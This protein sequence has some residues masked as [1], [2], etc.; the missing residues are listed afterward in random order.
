MN[1]LAVAVLGLASVF[2]AQAALAD[3]LETYKF[4]SDVPYSI[5]GPNQNHFQGLNGT[6]TLN[7]TTQKFETWNVYTTGGSSYTFA[8]SPVSGETLTVLKNDLNSGL[9]QQVSGY[10]QT[11]TLELAPPGTGGWSAGNNDG[12]FIVTSA[13]VYEYQFNA[14]LVPVSSVPEPG[15]SA[16]LALG[17]FSMLVFMRRREDV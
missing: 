17:L 5:T 16:L 14:S 9:W 10:G 3:T 2:T 15:V 11:L 1:K 12:A 13:N 8:N 7:L 6:F 4:Q